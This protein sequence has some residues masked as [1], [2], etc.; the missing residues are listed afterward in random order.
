M[1]QLNH[2]P[3]ARRRRGF[4]LIETALATVIVGVGVLA[5]MTA[6]QAF[7]RQNGWSTHA[8]T[9]QRLGNEIREMT[10]N[11]PRNDP[12]TGAAF[13]GAEA[14]ETWIGAF[15]DL[16]D[17]DGEGDGLI[18]SA[19]LSNGPINAQREVI[20]NM[21]GWAQEVYVFNVDPF[22]ITSIED[23]NSTTMIMVEVVV[24]YQAPGDDQPQ[25]MTR[26]SWI[27]PN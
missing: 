8:S 10:L 27:A 21:N 14:N 26:V 23:D 17:F 5:I 19:A 9:A 15:D 1:L 7:H 13:W 6:Q 4:T 20:A 22:N 18:F 24:T 12:V 11:L 16:D 3:R 2:R 25:E